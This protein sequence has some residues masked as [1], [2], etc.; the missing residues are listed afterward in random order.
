MKKDDKTTPAHDLTPRANGDVTDSD[1][2]P[3]HYRVDG[4]RRK[5]LKNTGG[6]HHCRALSLPPAAP[7][8][9]AGGDRDSIPPVAPDCGKTPDE[10]GGLFSRRRVEKN[11]WRHP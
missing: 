1:S 3:P 8:L 4:K 10:P 5:L 7:P 11:A 9:P 6:G 2:P